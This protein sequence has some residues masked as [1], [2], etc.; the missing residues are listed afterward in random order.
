[1]ILANVR[2]KKR[3]AF[4]SRIRNDSMCCTT[5]VQEENDDDDGQETEPVTQCKEQQRIVCAYNTCHYRF[6]LVR[7]SQSLSVERRV[8]LHICTVERGKFEF[9]LKKIIKQSF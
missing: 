7:S 4:S 8:L 2:P 9:F 5:T 1:M 6:Y 3:I